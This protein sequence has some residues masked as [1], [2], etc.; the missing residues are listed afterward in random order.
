MHGPVTGD[1]FGNR[2]GRDNT[3]FWHRYS[4]CWKLHRQHLDLHRAMLVP[5]QIQLPE[6]STSVPS[7][8]CDDFDRVHGA[9]GDRNHFINQ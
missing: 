7:Y 4:S 9:R 8:R 5:Y 3:T 2:P 6:H 1:V